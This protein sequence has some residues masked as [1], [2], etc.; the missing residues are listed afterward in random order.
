LGGIVGGA[1]VGPVGKRMSAVSREMAQAGGAPA[2]EQMAQIQQLGRKL[3][4]WG[5]VNA[6]LLVFAAVAM[7]IA[8]YV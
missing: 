4:R 2:P 7:A 5:R 8:R 3:Q 1:I 6:T